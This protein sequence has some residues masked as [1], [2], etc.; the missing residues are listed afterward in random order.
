M[1]YP[2]DPNNLDPVLRPNPSA[3]GT[4]STSSSLSSSSPPPLHPSVTNASYSAYPLYL[5]PQNA[6]LQSSPSPS[7]SLA[8]LPSPPLK[9]RFDSRI[10]NLETTLSNVV[11]QLKD[12]TAS[13]T[14]FCPLNPYSY[15]DSKP[16]DLPPHVTW[17]E[18]EKTNPSTYLHLLDRQG[19]KEEQGDLKNAVGVA[20]SL[21]R[22]ELDLA[23]VTTLEDLQAHHSHLYATVLALVEGRRWNQNAGEAPFLLRTIGLCDRRWKGRAVLKYVL[24][25]INPRRGTKPRKTKRELEEGDDSHSNSKKSR[26]DNSVPPSSSSLTRRGPVASK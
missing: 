25:D 11:S 16:N 7:D 9:S 22:K 15:F 24:H 6:G 10:S 18:P 26:I 20:K 13:V 12:A 21:C 4:S 23:E 2:W 17:F 8:Q 1:S 3:T 19:S 5:G 14:R